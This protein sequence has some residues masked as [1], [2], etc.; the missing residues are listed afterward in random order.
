MNNCP[1]CDEKGTMMCIMDADEF[2]CGTS[3]SWMSQKYTRSEHCRNRSVNMNKEIER[4]FLIT[5][6]LPFEPYKYESKFISQSY[7]KTEG[8]VTRVR[9][10]GDEAFLT[11]K[12]PRIEGTCD[13][14]EYAI[15][16]QDAKIII[17]RYCTSTV[18]KTR[19]YIPHGDKTIELEVFA[20][21]LGGLIIAEV[22][23]KAIDE[24]F[25][26]PVWFGR[27]IT[28]DHSYSNFE[29]SKKVST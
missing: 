5:S 17:E 13:E 22:E 7:I 4:R 11:L 18:E 16:V 6:P 10:S 27:E 8:L 24:E 28:D 19:Y 23:L 14:F 15:P 26:I 3:Y 29:L 12:G 2:R 21:K 9:V 20:G 1:F 25:T